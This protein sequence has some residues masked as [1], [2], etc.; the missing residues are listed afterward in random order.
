[1]CGS[2]WMWFLK[3]AFGAP[4]FKKNIKSSLIKIHFCLKKG[5]SVH[6]SEHSILFLGSLFLSTWQS[7]HGSVKTGSQQLLGKMDDFKVLPQFFDPFKRLTSLLQF[8]CHMYLKDQYSFLKNHSV[9]QSTSTGTL[10]LGT[11]LGNVRERWRGK[12]SPP[13]F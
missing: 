8:F 10:V 12:M 5:S 6:K 1:M 3:Q 2:F 11:V 4:L 13:G 7:A 9:I